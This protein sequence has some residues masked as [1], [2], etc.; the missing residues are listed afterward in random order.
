VILVSNGPYRLGRAVG[1]GTRPRLDRGVLGIAAFAAA[2][3]SRHLRMQQ[4]SSKEFEVRSGGRVAAGIDGEALMLDPPLTF[5]SHP[6]ALHVRIAPHHPGASPSALMPE[7][8]WG[9]V[10]ALARIAFGRTEDPLRPRR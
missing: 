3:G 1:S 8:P 6:Q 4:W 10:G 9:S 5:R 7:T 2:N